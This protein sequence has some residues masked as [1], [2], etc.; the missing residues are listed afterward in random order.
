MAVTMEVGGAL[1]NWDDAYA[2]TPHIPGG[3]GYPDAWARDAA[4]F[5]ATARQQNGIFMPE[6]EP[7]GLVVFIH[8]GYWMKFDP[9]SFSHLAAGPVARGWAVAMPG[10][11]LAPEARIAAMTQ[12]VGRGIAGAAQAVAGPVVLTGHSA[13]GHL[14]ARMV[15][16]DSPLPKEVRA[17][18]ARCV[19]ISGL[20]DLRPLMLT[21]MNRTLRL[22]LAEAR[23]ESPALLE[24]ARRVPVIAW[25]GAEERPE[26]LRQSRLLANIWHGLAADIRCVEAPGR[27]HFDVIADLT[28][29]GSELTEAVVSE[30]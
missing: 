24:P 29:P 17:R 13:G 20:F 27:H 23:A 7:R 5:R 3:E 12:Q 19:P 9:S 16:S 26:F 1:T 8:G 15:C 14:A 10:Y 4:A 6:G 22:D 18:V 25:V 21:E 2:N 28:A 30:A 11:T